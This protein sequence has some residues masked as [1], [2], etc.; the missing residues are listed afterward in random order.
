MH[1]NHATNIPFQFPLLNNDKRLKAG[2]A[3]FGVSHA[4]KATAAALVVMN[5][6]ERRGWPECPSY[7]G[8]MQW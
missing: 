3:C 8:T 6:E 5:G 7:P 1:I 4:T 2:K